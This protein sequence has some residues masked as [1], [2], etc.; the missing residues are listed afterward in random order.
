ME[1]GT[2]FISFVPS[3]FVLFAGVAVGW[4]FHKVIFRRLM[5]WALRTRWWG[6]EL[7]I[8][9]MQ[10]FVIPFFG[11]IGLYAALQLSPLSPQAIS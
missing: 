4:F 6:D 10:G 1:G 3:L 9:S 2:S 11:L 7:I 5:G 8:R